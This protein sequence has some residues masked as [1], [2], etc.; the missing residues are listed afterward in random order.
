MRT[1]IK[2]RPA[3]S[4]LTKWR[5]PR[6][7]MSRGD[8]QECTYGAMR[9]EPD[10]LAA[11]EEGLVAEQ[12][13]LC[14]YTGIRIRLNKDADGLSHPTFHLEHLRA[15]TLTKQER[16]PGEPDPASYGE[17]ADYGNLV[18]C[19]PQ[20]N[21]GFAPT[22]GAVQK[23][24]WP[25]S[26]E[27]HLFL[28]PLRADCAARFKFHSNGRMTATSDSDLRATTTITK[29][30]LGHVP[31][32]TAKLPLHPLTELRRTYIA[33][34]LRPPGRS[35][36]LADAQKLLRDMRREEA[37]VDGGGTA[38]LMEFCFAVKPALERKVTQLEAIR[39]QQK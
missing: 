7:L 19:W 14:A 30:N 39:K 16:K 38:E 1:I 17:D 28:S 37:Q 11:V 4:A 5:A 32:G 26:A 34:V 6:L 2:K 36:S 24:N 20:P 21:C 12:G 18:A 8:G 35:L 3:P 31:K 23:G 29:L 27:A 33:G 25:A 10:V 22:F 13:G 15:Q 9:A